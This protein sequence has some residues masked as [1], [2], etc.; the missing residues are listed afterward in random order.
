MGLPEL[1]AATVLT[2]ASLVANTSPLPESLAPASRDIGNGCQE[3]TQQCIPWS[4][5]ES[6]NLTPLVPWNSPDGIVSVFDQVYGE[7]RVG[8]SSVLGDLFTPQGGGAAQ[9]T[10]QQAV[11]LRCDN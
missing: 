10:F 2:A 7:G 8:V 9:A 1:G 6:S 11:E 5:A 4:F 3:C